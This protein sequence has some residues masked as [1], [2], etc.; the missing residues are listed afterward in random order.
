MNERTDWLTRR[1]AAEEIRCPVS[2]L[3]R[4]AW[5]GIGPSY[6]RAG[7]R[8]LYRRSDLEAWLEE[9]RVEPPGA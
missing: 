9:H 3:A 4:W 6:V 1:E 7:R 2:T 5:L 8:A